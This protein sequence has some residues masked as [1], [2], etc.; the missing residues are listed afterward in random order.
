[1][2]W[3]SQQRDHSERYAPGL[4]SSITPPPVYHLSRHP[5]TSKELAAVWIRIVSFREGD[6]M[7]PGL[8]ELQLI[9]AVRS[10]CC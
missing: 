3:F 10:W 9:G 8:G 7:H 6:P 4:T 2:V 1:M 5:T